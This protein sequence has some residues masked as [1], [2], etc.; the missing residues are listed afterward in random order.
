M[1][2]IFGIRGEDEKKKE[3]FTQIPLYTP[4]PLPPEP[5]EKE[6]ESNGDDD[7]EKRGVIIIDL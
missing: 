6:K 7:S 1:N 2:T 4:Q 5:P 3:E